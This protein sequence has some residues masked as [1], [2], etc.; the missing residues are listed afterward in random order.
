M[1]THSVRRGKKI[2]CT[3]LTRA[4]KAGYKSL[5]PAR[6][7]LRTNQGRAP[8]I[9][10]LWVH[11]HLSFNSQQ[12]PSLS[13]LSGSSIQGYILYK[14]IITGSPQS[15]KFINIGNMDQWES[16]LVTLYRQSVQILRASLQAMFTIIISA[17]IIV[18]HKH[19]L[20]NWLKL[21]VL[22]CLRTFVLHKLHL[23]WDTVN[24]ARRGFQLY[25]KIWETN[26]KSANY[27]KSQIKYLHCRHI[28][29]HLNL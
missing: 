13:G 10:A 12:G 27:L 14:F 8:F 16:A 21:V 11:I 25:T 24:I 5:V 20:L 6:R 9:C 17:N 3:G 28:V 2:F 29:P 22:F 23:L 15:P 7:A 1:G 4:A 19:I 18:W 26:I